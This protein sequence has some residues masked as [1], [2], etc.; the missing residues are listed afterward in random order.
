LRPRCA[1]SSLPDFAA[2]RLLERRTA[3]NRFRIVLGESIDDADAPHPLRLLR[4]RAASGHA[5]A[6]PPSAKM[7]SRRLMCRPLS[8]DHTL[9]HRCK[10]YRAVHHSKIDRRM[11]EMGQNAKTSL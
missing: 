11:A 1:T 4:A 8:D 10:E 5:T 6:A 2:Q 9:P 7:N 3:G